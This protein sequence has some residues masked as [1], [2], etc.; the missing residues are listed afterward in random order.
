[1][2][3]RSRD[4]TLSS[5]CAHAGSVPLNFVLLSASAQQAHRSATRADQ[6]VYACAERGGGSGALH[7]FLR[8][9]AGTRG[10]N[11]RHREGATAQDAFGGEASAERERGQRRRPLRQGALIVP[12]RDRGPSWH[13]PRRDVRR[14]RPCA[15]RL[16][17]GRKPDRNRAL[18]E[19]EDS[20]LAR[21]IP[22]ARTGISGTPRTSCRLLRLR[23]GRRGRLRWSRG[24]SGGGEA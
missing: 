4:A 16:L 3:Y 11:A 23:R 5:S 17:T 2:P 20:A 18:C 9:P 15:R 24:T 8:H 13:L 14:P 7:S 22:L 12:P 19:I 21:P 1:M 6:A 10:H